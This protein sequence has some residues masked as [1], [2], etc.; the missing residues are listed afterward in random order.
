M[1]KS[2]LLLQ[3]KRELVFGA[4]GSVGAAVAGE[5][6]AEGAE[7]DY[8]SLSPVSNQSISPPLAV[9]CNSLLFFNLR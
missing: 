7:P 3:G 9:I 6:A 4:G 8:I 2:R 5:F 1:N